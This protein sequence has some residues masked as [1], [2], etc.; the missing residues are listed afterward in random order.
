MA[1]LPPM[2]TYVFGLLRRAPDRPQIP[3]AEADAIQENHLAHL[4]RLRERGDLIVAGPFVDD[5]EL[6]GILIF[7]NRSMEEVRE[8]T[9]SDPALQT[10]RLVLELHEL[11]APAGL[12]VVPPDE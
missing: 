6:R 4:R 8:L 5:G 2:T 10:G 1:K 7:R 11:Y 12:R 3:E 9:R